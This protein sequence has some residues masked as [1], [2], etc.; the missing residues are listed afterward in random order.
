MFVQL[1]C[2][3]YG[4]LPT[5]RAEEGSHYS[6]YVSS[7]SFG[8]VAGEMLVRGSLEEIRKLFPKEGE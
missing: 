6:A 8:H 7:G 3:S 5:K 4:Y 1:T 2:G